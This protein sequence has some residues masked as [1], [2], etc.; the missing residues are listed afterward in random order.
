[1]SQNQ[2]ESIL[3]RRISDCMADEFEFFNAMQLSSQG[4]NV[5]YKIDIHKALDTMYWDFIL[6]VIQCFGF[7]DT[8]LISWI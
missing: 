8:F 5:T 6:K 4:S 3:D 7:D 2:F 1:M